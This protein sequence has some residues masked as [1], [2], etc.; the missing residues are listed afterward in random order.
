MRY[1][2]LL[3]AASLFLTTVIHAQDSDGFKR[4]Y[5]PI[6]QSLQDWDAV[7]GAWLSDA[8]PAVVNQEPIPVRTFPENVTPMEMLAL[9]PEDTRTQIANT[10][11]TNQNRGTDAQFWSGVN[12]MVSSVNCT[13]RRGRSYGDPHLVSFDGERF[14][15]QTVGEFVLARNDNGRM[16]VQTRQKPVQNDFSLNTAVAMNVNGDRVCLYAEDL[17]DNF[18]NT[19][20][21]VNG[22]P[23][24]ITARHYFLPNG[25]VVH[26]TGNNYVVHWPT[27]EGVNIRS[28]RTGSMSFYNVN[29]S[30]RGCSSNYSGV[31]GNAD[32]IGR[33]D[34]DGTAWRTPTTIFAGN[35]NN[36]ERERSAWV[37]RSFADQHRV[38]QAT[39]LF[40][41]GMGQSTFTFTD[42]SYP[43]AIRTI[44]DLDPVQRQRAQRA[45][46]NAGISRADMN[47]CIYDNAFM[48]ISPVPQPPVRQPVD[49]ETVRP[50]REP[51]TNDN[52]APPVREPIRSVNETRTVQ[53][54]P[55]GGTPVRS[56]D[57]V[58]EDTRETN[59]NTA[60]PRPT[61]EESTPTRTPTRTTP[62]RTTPTRTPTRTRPTRSTPTR[63][64]PTRTAPSRTPTRTTPSRSTPTRSSPSRSTPSRSTPTRSSPSRGGRGG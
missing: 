59:P 5:Q 30:I 53:G 16:E 55:G 54:T 10:A 23:V 20:L 31:L 58:R 9:V 24:E 11:Q 38:T 36:F 28:G 57:D 6:K 46:S 4:E 27:G 50:V 1:R 13:P 39:S 35:N 56:A 15:F 49:P 33:N 22:Q 61:G 47:G 45:C 17:P 19:P 43:R 34:F 52:P 44:N 3:F 7:R 37:T 12:N 18:R 60:V 29:V 2:F 42:R 63:T 51:V 21:R 64:T 48:N 26:R 25:G 8:I 41:Y 14:S 40:D 32:G 62:T